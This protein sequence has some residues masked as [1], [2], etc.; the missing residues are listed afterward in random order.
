VLVHSLE[1]E[2]VAKLVDRELPAVQQAR[3]YSSHQLSCRI[4][5]VFAHQREMWT[6]LPDGIR[7]LFTDQRQEPGVQTRKPFFGAELGESGGEARG[8]LSNCKGKECM[9]DV[10]IDIDLSISSGRKPDQA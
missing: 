5:A 10:D 3:S 1:G 7:D 9:F 8:V 4:A 6:H 2:F